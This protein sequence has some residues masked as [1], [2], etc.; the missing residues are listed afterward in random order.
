MAAEVFQESLHFIMNDIH[1]DTKMNGIYTEEKINGVNG[2]HK[3]NRADQERKV[4]GFHEET[5]QD[6]REHLK[7]PQPLLK[8]DLAEYSR[9]RGSTGVYA[10]S[11]EVDVMIVGAG[12]G[13]IYM[14]YE[15][16]K[17]GFKTVIYEAGEDL[18]GVWRFNT[19]PGA[20]TDSE[21]PG[22][23]EVFSFKILGKEN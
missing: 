5:K 1:Q 17:A 16:R 11:L 3:M 12:F 13:G 23:S 19:Y 22:K 10:D 21:V 8:R 9:R 2:E 14:L 7:Q 6:A 15:L 4:N 18:G 20:R